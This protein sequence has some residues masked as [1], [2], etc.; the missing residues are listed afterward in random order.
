MALASGVNKNNV[1]LCLPYCDY[2]VVASSVET[3]S[4][5]GVYVPE[6]VKELATIIHTW[7]PG[8]DNLEWMETV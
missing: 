4:G 7:Y 1:K 2:F 6:K 5:S 3:H 8:I